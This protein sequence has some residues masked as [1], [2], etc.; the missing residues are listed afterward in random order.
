MDIHPINLKQ[1]HP[2]SAQLNNLITRLNRQLTFS[3]QQQA[4]YQL[5]IRGFETSQPTNNAM[6]WQVS[7]GHG[8]MEIEIEKRLTDVLFSPLTNTE[9]YQLLPNALRKGVS[10]SV[11]E[12]W[13]Q[14]CSE[15]LG[16]SELKVSPRKASEHNPDLEYSLHFQIKLEHTSGCFTLHVD[17]DALQWVTELLKYWPNRAANSAATLPFP[18]Q[19]RIGNTSLSQGELKRLKSSDI[20]LIEQAFYTPNEPQAVLYAKQRAIGL[21]SIHNNQLRWINTMT[22]DN[23][24]PTQEGETMTSIDELPVEV[25]FDLG[26]KTMTLQQLQA[27]QQGEILSLELPADAPVTIRA[28][29][30]SVGQAELVQVG[31]RLA[32]R[33]VQWSLEDE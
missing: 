25:Q 6:L 1:I 18:M 17:E 2:V 5:A 16:T 26:Q 13:V 23:I 24:D 3:D 10:R 32:A 27:L 33:I 30:K 14:L 28:N 20:L 9:Q 21:V 12:P 31:D 7:G 15:R 8:R 11:F 29:G 4:S 19:I 22:T